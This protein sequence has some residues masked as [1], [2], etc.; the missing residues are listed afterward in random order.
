MLRPYFLVPSVPP[1]KT[2]ALRISKVLWGSRFCRQPCSRQGQDPGHEIGR[3]QHQKKKKKKKKKKHRVSSWRQG[4]LCLQT[5]QVALHVS[6][7]CGSC[8]VIGLDLSK[9]PSQ[10]AMPMKN[11]SLWHFRFQV[12][13]VLKRMSGQEAAP[14]KR[15]V[16]DACDGTTASLRPFAATCV[17]GLKVADETPKCLA[18]LETRFV[19][20]HACGPLK[21]STIDGID[22][23]SFIFKKSSGFLHFAWK[24]G[25]N[26]TTPKQTYRP[27][28][29]LPA[30]RGCPSR[31]PRPCPNGFLK[32]DTT[33]WTG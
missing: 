9:P 13:L 5:V 29:S 17:P 28:S 24:N 23:A 30:H 11:P 16:F 21:N 20:L 2:T 31:L 1:K 25:K 33:F 14:S 7:V 6:Q 19:L 3:F 15:T 8:L 12:S 22:L 26:L 27:E 18:Q 10:E 4:P 32:E